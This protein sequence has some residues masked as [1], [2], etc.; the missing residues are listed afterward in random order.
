MYV[1]PEDN[2]TIGQRINE[3]DKIGTQQN[4][5]PAYK[6]PNMTNHYHFEVRDIPKLSDI[7]QDEK[8]NH[9]FD[10]V[11]YLNQHRSMQ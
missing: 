2:L 1:T 5:I 3:D 4:I 8:I 10:P 11:E 7:P 6:N 9:V